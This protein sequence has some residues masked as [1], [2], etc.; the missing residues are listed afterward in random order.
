MKT[1][2]GKASKNKCMVGML[3][4]EFF[5]FFMNETEAVVWNCSCVNAFKGTVLHRT[6]RRHCAD[7]KP[8]RTDVERFHTEPF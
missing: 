7:G 1:L 6:V 3:F 2:L 5:M 4:Q 8:I